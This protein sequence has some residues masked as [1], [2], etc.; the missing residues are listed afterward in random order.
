MNWWR[1][2][3]PQLQQ[4][5]WLDPFKGQIAYLRHTGLE[6]VTLPLLSEYWGYKHAPPNPDKQKAFNQE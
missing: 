2:I 4:S 5:E 1:A 6:L 3:F